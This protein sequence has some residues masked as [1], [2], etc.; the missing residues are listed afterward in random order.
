MSSPSRSSVA[1]VVRLSFDRQ[2]R[3]WYEHIVIPDFQ[4]PY[5]WTMDDI[6][7][8]LDDVDD[9]RFLQE[10]SYRNDEYYFG[11]ICLRR[12]ENSLNLQLLDGQ[13]RLTS[14]MILAQLLFER[15]KKSK[16]KEIREWGNYLDWILG[17]KEKWKKIFIYEQPDTIAHIKNIYSQFQKHYEL[18]EVEGYSSVENEEQSEKTSIYELTLK[19][20]LAR[21]C[22][23]FR[24]GR[25]AVTFLGSS[26][27]EAEQFFQGENNRGLPMSM[28]DILK[29]YHMR[30]EDDEEKLKE[31]QRIWSEF[32]MQ[33]DLPVQNEKEH[34]VIEQKANQYWLVTQYVIPALLLSSGTWPWD[35]DNVKNVDKLKGIMGT[36]R[37]DRVVDEKLSKL[38][39]SKIGIFDLLDPINPGLNFFLML[40]QYRKIATS[41]KQ[42][43]I[44]QPI[45]LKFDDAEFI[46]VLALMAWVDRFLKT[47]LI[48]KDSSVITKALEEDLD[49]RSYAQTFARFLNCLK[50]NSDE[51]PGAFSQVRKVRLLGLLNYKQRGESLLLLP[52]RTSSPAACKRELIRMTTPEVMSRKI[53]NTN[54]LE[55]YRKAY[56]LIKKV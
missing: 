43:L 29:A 28:L 31:I 1:G 6:Q 40:D 35:K 39:N 37:H 10:T 13:Q 45:T 30:F 15:S 20:D 7:K 8:I 21:I 49:F 26:I 18:L 52:H 17:G 3:R 53:W 34:S 22:Y 23:I 27:R 2:G 50:Y 11:S 42:F 47:G 46:L 54:H 16:N 5:C 51:D 12:Q 14:F 33:E 9:L 36:H 56:N 48:E 38:D 25:F 55:G 24:H 4:R 19:R 32:N 41:V 44:N